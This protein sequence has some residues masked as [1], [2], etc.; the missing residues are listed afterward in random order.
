LEFLLKVDFSGFLAK[1]HFIR[2][3]FKK[4][5][6]SKLILAAFLQ[7]NILLEHIFKKMGSTEIVVVRLCAIF[8][9]V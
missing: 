6:F 9:P 7:K 1:E 2:A 8:R 4:N 5:F 3:H